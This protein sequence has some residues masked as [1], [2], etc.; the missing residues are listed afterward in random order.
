MPVTNDEMVGVWTSMCSNDRHDLV[1][2]YVI[3]SKRKKGI[4]TLTSHSFSHFHYDS[5]LGWVYMVTFPWLNAY[6]WVVYG[7]LRLVVKYNDQQKRASYNEIVRVYNLCAQMIDTNWEG[8]CDW[9]KE[10]EE[11]L[12]IELLY[13]LHVNFGSGTWNDDP[14]DPWLLMG[15]DH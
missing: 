4:F 8:L 11:N 7:N 6:M 15:C 10:K 1:R 12:H 9:F 5:S 13:H 3:G 14:C 2:V